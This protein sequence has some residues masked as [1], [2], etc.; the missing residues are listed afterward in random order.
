M[1]DY[2]NKVFILIDMKTN[3]FNT[4]GEKKMIN[5]VNGHEYT[6]INVNTLLDLDY[7]E[8]DEFC[9]FRQAL[10]FYKIKGKQMKGTKTVASLVFMSEDEEE[11]KETKEVS[12]KKKKKYFRVFERSSLE[13]KLTE[14]GVR[15]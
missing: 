6:G 2:Y 15:V 14:N 3:H 9:T 13:Q 4:M 1:F 12:K 8:G 7:N 11:D 10:D 5:F